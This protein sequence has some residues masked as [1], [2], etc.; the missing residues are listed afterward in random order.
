MKRLTYAPYFRVTAK[1]PKRK[2]K[3]RKY[4]P[5]QKLY[6]KRPKES[7]PTK[8]QFHRGWYAGGR[9][10][11]RRVWRGRGCSSRRCFPTKRAKWGSQKEERQRAP[12]MWKG[13]MRRRRKVF[14]SFWQWFVKLANKIGNCAIFRA[15]CWCSRYG[16]LIELKYTPIRDFLDAIC[17]AAIWHKT[18]RVSPNRWSG[19][20]IVQVQCDYWLANYWGHRDL[21]N[22]VVTQILRRNFQHPIHQD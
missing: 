1:E 17:A 21:G 6:S 9:E 14:W 15:F 5:R 8:Q 3:P 11:T 18:C 16:Q 2:Y 19:G 4:K 7:D 13:L 20:V 12:G 22:S 10:D